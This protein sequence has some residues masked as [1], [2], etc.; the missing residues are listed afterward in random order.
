M[1]NNKRVSV[2]ELQKEL[3]GEDESASEE[4]ARELALRYFDDGDDESL[5]VLIRAM[6]S[7]N[8][9][10]LPIAIA[11]AGL[12]GRRGEPTVASVVPYLSSRNLEIVRAAI[13]ALGS[14]RDSASNAVAKLETLIDHSDD[15][16]QSTVLTALSRITGN[17][18]Y[19]ESIRTPGSK[20]WGEA[21]F[22]SPIYSRDT[23]IGGRYSTGSQ[24]EQPAESM[25]STPEAGPKLPLR[26]SALGR[27]RIL[28]RRGPNAGT[29]GVFRALNIGIPVGISAQRKS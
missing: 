14:M 22:D 6:Q 25:Q 3:L 9:R 18:S 24:S 1:N 7:K 16:V 27:K 28:R 26:M 21:P 23:F 10:L 8:E 19:K 11:A 17:Y 12:L 20:Y 29:D 5:D 15:N 2:R 4:A 13:L